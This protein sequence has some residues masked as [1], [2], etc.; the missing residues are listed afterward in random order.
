MCTTINKPPMCFYERKA[1]QLK[2]QISMWKFTGICKQLVTLY[3]I[4]LMMF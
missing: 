2:A 4:Q 1:M 3:G